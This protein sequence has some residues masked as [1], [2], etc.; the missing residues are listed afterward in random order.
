M[1]IPP[2]VLFLFR[3]VLFSILSFSLFPYEIENY[4][5]KVF[6]KNCVGILIGIA[7]N[8]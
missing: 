3:I 1:V 4:P 5:V 8:L 7:V 6:V 2:E